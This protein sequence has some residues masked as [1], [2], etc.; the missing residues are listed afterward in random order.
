MKQNYEVACFFAVRE[1]G[2]GTDIFSVCFSHDNIS[3]T[4]KFSVIK[5][6]SNFSVTYSVVVARSWFQ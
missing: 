1:F 2:K 6:A 3:D 5:Q 4:N